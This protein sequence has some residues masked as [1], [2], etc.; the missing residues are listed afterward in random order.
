[1]KYFLQKNRR[2]FLLLAVLVLSFILISL[3]IS[4]PPEF[5]R[6]NAVDRALV[7]I[8][9]PVQRGTTA[10]LSA[11]KLL[12]FNYIYLVRLKEKNEVMEDRVSR[13]E[14]ALSDM[15]EK[16]AAT[17]RLA[18]LLL[19][20]ENNPYEVRVARI[21]GFD[22]GYFKTF[23]LDKGVDDG[24]A[25]SMPVVAARGVVGRIVRVHPAFS[26]VLLLLDFNSAV[27]AV[28]QRTRDK[29]IVTGIGGDLCEMKYV[30]FQADVQPGDTVVTS[31]QGG[32][33]P[34][35]LI[36]GEVTEVTREGPGLFQGVKVRPAVAAGK[37]EEVLVILKEKP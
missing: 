29:G 35:G 7:W 25:V 19:F 14:K 33:F 10:I 5:Y 2:L 30:D 11:V 23:T 22:S 8:V 18:G 17:D 20:K 21:I 28:I 3:N 16:A 31:G 27:D 13:L 4:R 6:L 26:Q 24:L 37:L 34:E 9:S 15:R 1:M 36:I 32:I 12:W